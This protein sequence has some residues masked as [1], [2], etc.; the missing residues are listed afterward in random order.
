MSS[1]AEA[2]TLPRAGA[3]G[4]LSLPQAGETLEIEGYASLWGQRDLGG[5]VVARGAFAE[6]LA[7]RPAGEVAMLWRHG[8]RDSVGLWDEIEEDTRGLRVRGRVTAPTAA[9]LVRS[10]AVDGLSIGYRTARARRDARAGVRV[11]SGV[12][13]REVSLVAFPMLPGARVTKTDRCS[14]SLLGG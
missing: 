10:G 6:S 2:L 4:A 9:A 1:G 8:P 3:R 7:L 11:L 12:D 13:L 5:D 14:P